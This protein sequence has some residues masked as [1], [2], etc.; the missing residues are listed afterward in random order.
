MS[1]FIYRITLKVGYQT[2]YFDFTDRLEAIR[3]AETIIEHD[4]TSED[5]RISTCAISVEVI[6]PEKEAEKE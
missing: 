2:R 4:V 3:F 6:D 1:K 5:H